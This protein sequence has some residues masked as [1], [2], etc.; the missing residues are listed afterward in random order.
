MARK[1]TNSAFVR[2]FII[3]WTHCTWSGWRRTVWFNICSAYNSMQ[4]LGL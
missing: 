3:S 2:S 1:Y 4:H